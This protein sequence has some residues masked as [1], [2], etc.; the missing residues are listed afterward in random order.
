MPRMLPMTAPISRFRLT[1]RNRISNRTTAAPKMAPAG[2]RPAKVPGVEV[3]NRQSGNQN[4][5]DAYK[6]QV[7]SDTSRGQSWG[8]AVGLM[9][10]GVI[11]AKK[12][13]PA[14]HSCSLDTTS[15]LDSI[16]TV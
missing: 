15:G 3:H 9:C 13:M 6:N 11:R 4:K 1:W 16:A 12:I 2:G 5:Y 7:H 8:S 14:T 10:A